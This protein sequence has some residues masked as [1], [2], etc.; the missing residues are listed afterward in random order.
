MALRSLR[1]PGCTAAGRRLIRKTA[2][3]RPRLI[4]DVR[5]MK[6]SGS[7]AE[8]IHVDRGVRLVE[9]Q[10]FAEDALVEMG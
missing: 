1:R 2:E 5:S 8:G 9:R 4:A 7:A 6:G 10:G 3:D